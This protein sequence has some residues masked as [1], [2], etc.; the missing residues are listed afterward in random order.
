[1]IRA[2]RG[3]RRD[4]A[5]FVVDGDALVHSAIGRLAEQ[6]N[7]RCEGFVSGLEFFEAIDK[8]TAGCV[9]SEIR[10]PDMAGLQLQNRLIAG[11]YALP[12]VFHT[13]H[14]SIELAVQAVRNGAVDFLEKPFKEQRV[15]EAIQRGLQL[16]RTRWQRKLRTQ[17]L[18]EQLASLS[19][20]EL[21]IMV[22]V[23]AGKKN[24]EIADEEGIALRTVEKLRAQ[25]MQKV[26]AKTL[27][28]L[29]RFEL[30]AQCQFSDR[31]H[32]DA[33]SASCQLADPCSP[34][35]LLQV[36]DPVLTPA[37]V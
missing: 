4:P 34:P 8:D 6:M 36:F 5:V 1:M 28:D 32:L 16:D 20:R 25:L 12:V 11:G 31:C 13:A 19:T 29:I 17:E 10:I 23:N 37:R 2:M 14:P 27:Q 9:V 24:Q 3:R 35:E 33:D 22:K 30:V 26:G 7:L 21:N 15:W 18:K